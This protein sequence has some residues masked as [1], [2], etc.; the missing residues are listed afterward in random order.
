[1]GENKNYGKVLKKEN[2]R[3]TNHRISVLGIIES[4]EEPI[5]AENLYIE[6]KS[7]GVSISLSTVY[8]ILDILAEKEIV[9]KTDI[10]DNHK[11]LYEMNRQ[12][13]NHHLICVKCRKIIPIEDCPFGDYLRTLEER[14]GFQITGHR[15]EM[16]GYCGKCKTE[17]PG[18]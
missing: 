15:L 17:K 5:S 10:A 18:K 7:K 11:S 1:M 13:H 9:I 8:R 2:L 4:S 6:L 14:S 16:F 12:D 3:N